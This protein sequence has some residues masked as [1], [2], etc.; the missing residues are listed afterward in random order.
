MIS[1]PVRRMAIAVRDFNG[2]GRPYIAEA[3]SEAPDV[4]YFASGAVGKCN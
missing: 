4:L 3:R 2:D 1:S